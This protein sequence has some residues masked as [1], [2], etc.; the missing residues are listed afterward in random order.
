MPFPAPDPDLRRQW[1]WLAICC[2]LVACVVYPLMN[3]VPMPA[4]QLT[5]V[6]AASFGPALAF[7]CLGLRQILEEERRSVAAQLAALSNLLAGGL[8][9]AMLLVQLAIVHS[10]VPPAGDELSAFV[11]QRVWDVDLGLDVAFDVFIGLGTALFG[12]AM[13]RDRRYGRL[14]GGAG[15]VVGVVVILGLN[16]WTFPTPPAE[17]GLLDS[18]PV[19]GLWY[20]AVVL[21][22]L[23]FVA[24]GARAARRNGRTAA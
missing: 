5:V 7:A 8:V 22:T 24:A 1:R 2:G 12:W 15:V 6:L 19:C 16:F 4:P 14:L 10:R 18:G 11:R 9:T 17:A 3:F 20:L 23:R 13:M 21:V